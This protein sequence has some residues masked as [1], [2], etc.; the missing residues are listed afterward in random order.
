[1]C[2]L[3]HNQLNCTTE[4]TQSRACAELIRCE[5]TPH[6]A[7]KTTYMGVFRCQRGHDIL[8]T[9]FIRSIVGESITLYSAIMNYNRSLTNS[10]NY[11]TKATINIVGLH[12]YSSMLTNQWTVARIIIYTRDTFFLNRLITFPAGK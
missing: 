8:V 12:K 9:H 3:I 1:M 4:I 7:V 6:Q 10:Q 2:T 11:Y 5:L